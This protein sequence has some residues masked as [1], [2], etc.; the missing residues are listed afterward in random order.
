MTPQT[1]HSDAKCYTVKRE[2][3]ETIFVLQNIGLFYLLCVQ[4]NSSE[5]DPLSSCAPRQSGKCS[6]LGESPAII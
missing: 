5:A 6:P 4:F 2:V 1:S 3:T